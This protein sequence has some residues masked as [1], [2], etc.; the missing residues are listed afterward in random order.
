[1]C[2]RL[3]SFVGVRRNV[4]RGGVDSCVVS[5]SPAHVL[6]FSVHVLCFVVCCRVA[7]VLVMY[8]IFCLYVVCVVCVVCVCSVFIVF[9]IVIMCFHVVDVVDVVIYQLPIV[10]RLVWLY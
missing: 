4:L 9:I 10:H 8:C 7:Y 6:V 3:V 1:M 5:S 2:C